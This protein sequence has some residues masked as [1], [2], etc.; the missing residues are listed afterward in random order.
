[1]SYKKICRGPDTVAHRLS[2]RYTFLSVILVAY[3]LTCSTLT[4]AQIPRDTMPEGPSMQ[5][6]N[7]IPDDSI[8][9]TVILKH[10]QNKNLLEIRRK[11]EA[12]GFWD[13]FPPREARVIS[14]QLAIDLGH[15]IIMKLPANA[16]RTLNLALENGAWGAFDTEVHLSYDYLSIYQDYIQKRAENRNKD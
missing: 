12:N 11:L 5:Q 13:V 4:F 2:M 8:M 6:A 3:F 10:Q 9:V 7:L 1:M 14:W 16:V 15:V